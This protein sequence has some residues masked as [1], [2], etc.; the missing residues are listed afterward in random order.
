LFLEWENRKLGKNTQT[1]VIDTE[2]KV[3]YEE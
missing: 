1:V 3:A 2:I